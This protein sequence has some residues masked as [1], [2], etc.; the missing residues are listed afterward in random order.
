MSLRLAIV[1]A[2]FFSLNAEAKYN[3]HLV[4]GVWMDPWSAVLMESVNGSELISHEESQ[5]ETLCR[6]YRKEPAKRQLF[7]SQLFISLSWRESLHGPENWVEFNGGR[8]EGLYQ[9]NPTLRTA[10]G[11]ADFVLFDPLQNIR[12]AVKM[13]EKLTLRFGSFLKGS[14]GG[15]AAYWQP[16]RSTS[17]LNRKNRAFILN[18]VKQACATGDIAY[19][20]PSSNA[21]AGFE[22]S[23]NDLD[24]DALGLTPAQLEPAI[25]GFPF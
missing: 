14:K 21:L 5:I 8:N 13:A 19:H 16:L 18:S 15:M 9:I 20:S 6:G 3:G 1:F 17:S 22:P 2:A 10:Y 24:L 12:C 23:F 25:P 4:P 11:C 7:W